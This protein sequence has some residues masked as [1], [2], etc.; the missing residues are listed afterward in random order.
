M[1]EDMTFKLSYDAEDEIF[2]SILYKG[3]ECCYFCYSEDVRKFH[4]NREKYA[5]KNEDIQTYIRTL[6]AYETLAKHYSC[7]VKNTEKLLRDI[8]ERIDYKYKI[9]KGMSQ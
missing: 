5:Y 2:L 9:A 6:G 8:R 1:G 7:S 3:Y 4:S